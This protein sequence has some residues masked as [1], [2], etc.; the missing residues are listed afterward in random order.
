MQYRQN[1]LETQLSIAQAKLAVILQQRA[2]PATCTSPD[3]DK[4]SELN[5][6]HTRLKA[7]VAELEESWL[8]TA[9]EE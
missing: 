8:E 2:D 6:A 4:L 1:K 3:R 9:M 7:K 5:A